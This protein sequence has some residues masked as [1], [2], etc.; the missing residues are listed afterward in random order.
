MELT[1]P[2]RIERTVEGGEYIFYGPNATLVHWM[3]ASGLAS[4]VM[5]RAGL[6]EE[7]IF[8]ALSTRNPEDGMLAGKSAI[9]ALWYAWP[10]LGPY[11][12]LETLSDFEF[13]R[14]FYPD[15]REHVNHQLRVFWLGLYLFEMRGPIRERVLAEIGAGDEAAGTAEFLRRW[16]ACAIYHDIGYVLECEGANEPG[17]DAWNRVCRVINDTLHAPLSGLPMFSERLGVDAE[18]RPSTIWRFSGPR[19]RPRGPSS[20]TRDRIC[21]IG[22]PI[23]EPARGSENRMGTGNRP[24]G[25]IMITP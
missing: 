3:G 6:G 15:Y 24:S 5:D 10:E 25:G 18:I 11:P 19:S 7:T 13:N 8:R 1:K 16:S 4:E 14:E 9:K 22:S 17:S 20:F 12:F 23:M 21:W 2:N